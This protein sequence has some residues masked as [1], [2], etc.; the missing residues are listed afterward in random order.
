[1]RSVAHLV[2]LRIGLASTQRSAQA[3]PRR[4]SLTSRIPPRGQSCA[5][6]IA[7]RAGNG[8]PN[9]RVGLWGSKSKLRRVRRARDGADSIGQIID[10][11]SRETVLVIDDEARIRLSITEI[12]EEIGETAIEA[13]PTLVGAKRQTLGGRLS[14]GDYSN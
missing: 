1:M 13:N 2:K 9:P 7:A 8:T 6:P 3:K 12:L 11:G 10:R 14:A 5:P 4:I